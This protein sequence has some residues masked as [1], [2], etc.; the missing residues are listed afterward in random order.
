M[1]EPGKTD[2]KRLVRERMASAEP[3]H[4]LPPEVVAELATH[5]EE[6]YEDA[7]ATSLTDDVAIALTLQEVQEVRDWH[8]LA[9]DIRGA[10]LK[11]DSMNHRTKSLWLPG[12]AS[13]AGASL[14]LLVLTEISLQ[15]HYLVRLHGGWGRRFYIGWVIGQVVFGALGAF[16]S[17]RAGGTRIARVVAG[18]FPAIVM[19]I[20]YA[21]VIPVS[22]LYEHN[23]F[24]FSH[25]TRFWLGAFVWVVGPAITLLL[26]AAPFLRESK[27]A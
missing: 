19:L 4:E 8:V 7:R 18:T 9:A 21:I 23:Q 2:W 10:R 22:A 15:P 3:A 11:E 27:A 14:F 13:F 26:G 1:P 16:L 24:I 12:L 20:V 5:L 6:L 17:Q 25:E